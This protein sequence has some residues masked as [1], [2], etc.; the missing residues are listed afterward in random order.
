MKITRFRT[1]AETISPD[2]STGAQFSFDVWVTGA[3]VANDPLPNSTP[4]AANRKVRLNAYAKSSVQFMGSG[5]LRIIVIG[6]A[7]LVHQTWFFDTT[8]N[9]WVAWGINR[10]ITIA[11]TNLDIA[12]N[13]SPGALTNVDWFVQIVSTTGGP[14]N[15][16]YGFM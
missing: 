6:G 13:V 1:L 14:T 3:P 9:T 16:G 12:G 15:F 8:L 4:P 7:T 11:T 5:T 2:N 10:T